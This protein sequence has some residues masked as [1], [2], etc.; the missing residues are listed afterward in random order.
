MLCSLPV[1]VKQKGYLFTKVRKI[2]DISYFL[3]KIRYLKHFDVKNSV[4]RRLNDIK[5]HQPRRF[6][7]TTNNLYK[8]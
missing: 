6:P 2:N 5:I 4:K 3:K 1:N 7:F 8:K